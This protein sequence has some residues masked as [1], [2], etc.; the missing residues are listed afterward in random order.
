VL[1]SIH[2]KTGDVRWSSTIWARNRLGSGPGPTPASWSWPPSPRLATSTG[3]PEGG[4]GV[5]RIRDREEREWA[6]D[7]GA[8]G[9]APTIGT[10]RYIVTER[11]GSVTSPRVRRLELAAAHARANAGDAVEWLEWAR[12][13]GSAGNAGLLQAD[14]TIIVRTEGRTMDTFEGRVPELL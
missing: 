14:P 12:D 6:P 2:S 7:L 13:S 5:E 4:R 1:R 9:S 3:H 10:L 11:W 8:D